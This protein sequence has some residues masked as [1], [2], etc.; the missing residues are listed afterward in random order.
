MSEHRATIEW[1]RRGCEFKYETY[2]RAHSLRF[3]GI[4]V[5]GNAAPGNIPATVKP[6]AGLDAEQAFVASVS[7]C[8]LVWILHIACAALDRT[9]GSLL[10]REGDRQA[11]HLE[12]RRHQRRPPSSR[13]RG[14]RAA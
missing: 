11:A 6:H 4:E 5:Q 8:H 9:D 2:P 10:R 3:Q 14:S 12:Q 1:N 7:S 13:M